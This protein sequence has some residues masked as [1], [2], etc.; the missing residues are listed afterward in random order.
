MKIVIFGAA[1]SIGSFLAK[2]YFDSKHEILL[3]VKNENIKKLAKL[4][5]LKNSKKI[6]LL[7][8]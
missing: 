5:N 3:F 2:K 6:Y 1:G 8:I 7:I 4:L